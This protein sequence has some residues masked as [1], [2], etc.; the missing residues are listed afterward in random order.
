MLYLDQI[1]KISELEAKIVALQ[2]THKI[3]DMRYQTSLIKEIIEVPLR[4]QKLG[5]LFQRQYLHK[6][7]LQP[8]SSSREIIIEKGTKKKSIKKEEI[9]EHQRPI[10]IDKVSE[11]SP[12]KTRDQENQIDDLNFHE[13][14]QKSS[15]AEKQMTK[16]SSNAPIIKIR[17]DP[18]I[19][20]VL[21]TNFESNKSSKMVDLGCQTLSLSLKSTKI[22][23]DDISKCEEYT[24]TEKENGIISFQEQSTLGDTIQWQDGKSSLQLGV[25]KIGVMQDESQQQ[26]EEEKNEKNSYNQKPS[27][28]MTTKSSQTL[29]TTISR[30]SSL[31]ISEMVISINIKPTPK[32]YINTSPPS[33]T[34]KANTV[35][36]NKGLKE[37]YNQDDNSSSYDSQDSEYTY[38]TLSVASRSQKQIEE[39]ET[40]Q[41]KAGQTGRGYNPFDLCPMT[42]E[43]TLGEDKVF[44]E[45]KKD[46]EA[47]YRSS[48]DSDSQPTLKHDN[49]NSSSQSDSSGHEQSPKSKGG[50]GSSLL[51]SK[52]ILFLQK[53]KDLIIKNKKL[54]KQVI[55]LETEID[56]L[57]QRENIEEEKDSKISEKSKP[58][59]IQ[60]SE[61]IQVEDNISPSFNSVEDNVTLPSLKSNQSLEQLAN[62][63]IPPLILNEFNSLVEAE[64][65]HRLMIVE[66][67]PEGFILE[68]EHEEEIAAL[69][70]VIDNLESRSSH[71]QSEAE[72]LK[73]ELELN[74]IQLDEQENKIERLTTEIDSLEKNISTIKVSISKR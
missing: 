31:T 64:T 74:K 49:N 21:C 34:N 44:K 9:I 51:E 60:I 30:S 69:E 24:Q 35:Q 47:S 45:K 39:I 62:E 67:S 17:V 41:L 7:K 12:L 4:V 57:K 32:K 48:E 14:T 63:S 56:S 54:Q 8:E 26:Q 16:I 19:A 27:A 36:N 25:S 28:K 29:S 1:K 50:T 61:A 6:L 71:Q 3:V 18:E 72:E 59:I 37:K 52:A 11:T 55:D 65:Q 66:K 38:Q 2:S 58:E 22:Q 10:M 42:T 46:L 40:P 15:K 5:I 73:K 43:P 20:E 13:S 68:A 53:N 70:L 33:P 23:T